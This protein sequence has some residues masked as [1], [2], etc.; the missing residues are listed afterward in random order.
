[1]VHELQLSRDG[2]VAGVRHQLRCFQ[3][4]RVCWSPGEESNF[5][6]F[7]ELVQGCSNDVR[8]QCKLGPHATW[9]QYSLLR[10]TRAPCGKGR[11]EWDDLC[12]ALSVLGCNSATQMKLWRILSAILHLG[13]IEME[14]GCLVNK[15]PLVTAAEL[16]E[17]DPSV[18]E[19]SLL[20]PTPTK[21]LG[22]SIGRDSLCRTL[23]HGLVKW[24]LLMVNASLETRFETVSIINI[25]QVPTVDS[26]DPPKNPNPMLHGIGRIAN[27]LLAEVCLSKVARSQFKDST[28]HPE[29]CLLYTSDAADEEDSVDLGGR[30]II[31]KKKKKHYM[32]E[33][34]ILPK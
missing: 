2:S 27:N 11:R 30:R 25:V 18:I 19:T 6:V 9:L 26:T 8:E 13:D 28:P 31:K 34:C 1:M 17:V 7:Y 15:A 22:A 33:N 20:Q 5:L 21:R 23:Y 14:D 3:E 29:S 24:V 12:T 32:S 16:L 10:E 4:G